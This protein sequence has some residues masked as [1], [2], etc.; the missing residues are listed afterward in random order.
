VTLAISTETGRV[1]GQVIDNQ[2]G[3]R[4]PLGTAVPQVLLL[5]RRGYESVP[6]WSVR[7]EVVR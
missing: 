7:L 6:A 3:I 1:I 5:T 4:G 2:P